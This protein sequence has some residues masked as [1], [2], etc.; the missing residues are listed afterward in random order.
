MISCASRQDRHI[1]ELQNHLRPDS[2]RAF[3]FQCFPRSI[4]TGS[5]T[6]SLRH[7]FD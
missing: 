3:E 5:P 1:G 7:D 4:A 6:S 2:A